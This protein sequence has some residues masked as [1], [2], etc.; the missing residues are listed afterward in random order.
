MS[1]PLYQP[2]IRHRFEESPSGHARLTVVPHRPQKAPRVPF[3]VLV[4]V[5]LVG[6]VAGLLL[7]NTSMQQASFTG[8]AMEAKASSLKAREQALKMQL[9]TMRDPQRVAVRAKRLGMVPSTSPAFI[10]LSD[11]RVSGRAE[12][13]QAGTG[14]RITALPTR[15]PENLR[16]K[17][18]IVQAQAA[19]PGKSGRDTG[20]ASAGQGGTAGT[21]S[22]HAHR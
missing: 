13:A 14:M 21:K 22:L 15:K 4:S 12:P 16:P 20:A 17:P 6:G 3:L 11:G 9:D 7:F 18:V 1:I 5:L 10:Q 2:R 19:A 8:T